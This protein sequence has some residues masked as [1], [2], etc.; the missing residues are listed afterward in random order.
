MTT[1]SQRLAALGLRLPPVALPVA[2]YV[3]AAASGGWVLTSGQLPT[4]E[5]RLLAAGRVGDEVSEED[6]VRCARVAAL[7][8]LAAAASVTGGLDNIARIVKVTV[9]VASASDYTG[10][11]RVANGA[12]EL[13]GEVFGAAGAH[14]RS[15]VG[16]AVLPLGAPVEV[17]LTVEPR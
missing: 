5:G 16:V 2:A 6:G 4:V 13:L 17:E 10:Q 1:P 15:A 9:Y 12:S 14:V 11:P 3:P 8:A 7:N